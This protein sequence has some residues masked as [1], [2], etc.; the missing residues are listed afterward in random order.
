MTFGFR[1]ILSITKSS[2]R[3]LSEKE[4]RKYI[5]TSLLYNI[6]ICIVYVYGC[7]Y[8]YDIIHRNVNNFGNSYFHHG[9]KVP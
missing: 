9:L 6:Y 8:L 7:K 3:L 1:K 2:Y 4:F 5:G